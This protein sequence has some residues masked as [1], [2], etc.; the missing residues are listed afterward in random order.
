[1]SFNEVLLWGLKGFG[2]AKYGLMG[3]RGWV[4][5]SGFDGVGLDFRVSL[6][7]LGVG[8]IDLFLV[9]V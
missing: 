2:W 5:G 8:S 9:N 4:L 6:L 3:T 1:M 7:G